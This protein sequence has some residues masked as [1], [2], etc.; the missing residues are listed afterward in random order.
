V[1]GST[2]NYTQTAGTTTVDGTLAGAASSS[3]Y[4][5]G[6]NLYGTGTVD[7]GVVDSST[8]TPG[9]SSTSTGEL[10][11]GG[12]YKQNASGVLDITIGGDTAGTNYDQLD[13][14]RT[15]SL[16]GTLNIK[17]ANGYVPPIGTTFDI[18]N[19]SSI[20]GD[21][22]TIDGLSINSTEHFTVTTVSGDE[23]ELTVVKGAA[24]SDSVSFSQLPS[25]GAHYSRFG[26]AR[27]NAGRHSVVA[28]VISGGAYRSTLAL[29]IRSAGAAAILPSGFRSLAL[30]NTLARVTPPMAASATAIGNQYRDIFSGPSRAWKA[31]LNRTGG[32]N[33]RPMDDFGIMPTPMNPAG[34]ESGGVGAM[35]I[36]GISAAS[37]NGA[38]AMNH[39]RFECGVDVG[40]AV[41]TGR[42]RL[43]KALW[44]SP[45]S[46]DALGI[47]YI[48]MTPAH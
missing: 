14:T 24:P 46:S 47:G 48:T 12:A 16:N 23:I 15:A 7:Y 45:D 34:G 11:V 9:N 35:G 4:L 31:D 37:Y 27:S 39:M 33:L 22:S 44:A 28:G 30:G 36:S 32:L 20:T 29:L 3:L 18:L 38:S 13:I 40:A 21:F 5:T 1:G 2:S 8:I 42:K 19:A 41:K 26:F 25:G 43:L 6:G 17:L 10:R